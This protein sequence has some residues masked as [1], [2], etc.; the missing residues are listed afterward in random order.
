MQNSPVPLQRAA[1]VHVQQGLR[2]RYWNDDSFLLVW[3]QLSRWPGGPCTRHRR[4]SSGQIWQLQSNYSRKPA[5]TRCTWN[6]VWNLGTFLYCRLPPPVSHHPL[7]WS[8]FGQADTIKL[9]KIRN[10]F[11]ARVCRRATLVEI[12][13]GLIKYDGAFD[14]LY[15]VN[16]VDTCMKDIIN[17]FLLFEDLPT[18][19]E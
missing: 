12:K 7:K 2:L 16:F 18:R 1:G 6:L 8:L 4:R 9:T 17:D 3:C 10:T 11:L 15:G 14:T 5:P 13:E 19:I